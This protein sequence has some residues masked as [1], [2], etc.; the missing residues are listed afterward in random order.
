MLRRCKQYAVFL[1]L[2]L[3]FANVRLEKVVCTKYDW[4]F[5]LANQKYESSAETRTDK[6]PDWGGGGGGTAIHGL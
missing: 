4:S 1:L 5:N 6:I 2:V 3:Y